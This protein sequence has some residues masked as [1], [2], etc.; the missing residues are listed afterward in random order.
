MT[1]YN[2]SDTGGPG[3]CL[4]VTELGPLSVAIGDQVTVREPISTTVYTDTTVVSQ[5]VTTYVA[6]G[7]SAIKVILEIPSIDTGSEVLPLSDFEIDL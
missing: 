4:L 2:V 3:R 1:F 6:N 5:I 7:D